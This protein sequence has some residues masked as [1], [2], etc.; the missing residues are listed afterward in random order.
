MTC[1]AGDQAAANQAAITDNELFQMEIDKKTKK[2]SFRTAKVT[3]LSCAADGRIVFNKDRGASE[4]FDVEWLGPKVAIK[5]SNG[6][7]IAVKP[8][9]S[10]LASAGAASEEGATYVYELV[11]RPTL[12]LRG[13]NGFVFVNEKGQVRS[14]SVVPEVFK[15]HVTAGDCK[16]SGKNGNWAVEADGVTGKAGSP[17]ILHFEFVEHSKLVIKA[18]NGKYL[19]GFQNGDF[20]ATGTKIDASTLFEY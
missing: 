4:W 15:L 18:S 16:I 11:N 6:K 2:W 8:N 14:N 12:V 17:E 20:K 1:N 10:L 3:F 19:Q 5:A 9:G 13:E 7:Y